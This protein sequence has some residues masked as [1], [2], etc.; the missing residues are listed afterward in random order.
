MYEKNVLEVR[1]Y[2]WYLGQ[3]PLKLMADLTLK[4]MRLDFSLVFPCNM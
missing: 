4:S 2:M 3:V 1:L